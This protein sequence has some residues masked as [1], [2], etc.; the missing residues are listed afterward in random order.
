M[1]LDDFDI[2]HERVLADFLHLIMKH[3][4]K[5][6]L[7]F[8]HSIFGSCNTE[9]CSAFMRNCRDRSKDNYVGFDQK[10][11]IM[12]QLFDRIHCYYA[13][14]YDPTHKQKIK[15]NKLY[16]PRTD[17]FNQYLTPQDGCEENVYSFGYEFNYDPTHKS[18][19]FHVVAVFSCL[20]DE[21]LHNKIYHI[22]MDQFKME[23]AKAKI[24]HKSYYNK[25]V[26]GMS[27]DCI[28]ATMFYCNY[29]ELQRQL[30]CTF[31]KLSQPETIENV[32]KRHSNYYWFAV[33][34]KKSINEYGGYITDSS[35]K[36]F[37]HGISEQ[38]LFSST[39]CIQLFSPTSTTSSFEVA[40]NFTNHNQGIIVS[41]S[42]YGGLGSAKFSSVSWLSDYAN[43]AEYIFIK[44]P[45]GGY[46]TIVNIT[47][48][49]SG[50]Q[51]QNILK[52]LQNIDN[53]TNGYR[54]QTKEYENEICVKLIAHQLSS[55]LPQYLP[56]NI[57]KDDIYAQNMIVQ[58]FQNR[59]EHIHLYWRDICNVRWFLDLF[60]C[61]KCEWIKLHLLTVLFPNCE[62]VLVHNIKLCNSILDEILEYISNE[63]QL[64]N[65][66]MIWMG[67]FE[68]DSPLTA[69][70][71]IKK[72]ANKFEQNKWS[73][74]LNHDGDLSVISNGYVCSDL[75]Y[76]SHV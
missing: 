15:I 30:T 65:I 37:Y 76:R 35:V 4:R 73:L 11:I 44:V 74:F 14:G 39:R 28:T 34:L 40:V 12:Q 18:D 75:I 19:P 72:Y 20:K 52:A 41:F 50:C 58:Y 3:N 16:K 59:K 13:H 27:L 29:D 60:C 67:Y 53:Y 71:A 63:N 22:T 54:R 38:L 26:I 46:L 48:A 61:S 7:E 10:N 47:D 56:Y 9:H 66:K 1:T 24:H 31:R 70:N 51:Y 49:Q 36:C 5:A 8:I 23:F 57:L 21:L 69:T 33:L 62:R 42:D 68:K 43:E 64:N 17:R 32:I 25:Q 2:D 6:E 55:T 45:S